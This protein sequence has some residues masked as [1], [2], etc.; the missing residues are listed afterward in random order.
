[1]EECDLAVVGGSFA[2]L[3]CAHAAAGR[4]LRTVVL[5]RKSEPG[6][7][8]HTTGLL[9]K[10]AAEGLGVPARLTQKI[11]GVR[12][13]APSLRSIDLDSP[14][15]YFLATD[16]AG[17]L[18]WLA[19]RA[20]AVGASVRYGC[21]YESAREINE[22]V[23]IN[24]ALAARWIMGADGPRSR[25]ARDFSL[26]VNRRFL[27]GVESEFE[28]VRDV[29]SGRLHCFLDSHLAPGYIAWVIPGVHTTQIGLACSQGH[30]PD[31]EAFVQ[32]ISLLFNFDS[33][34]LVGR[35]GGLI[36]VGGCVTPFSR[37]RATLIGDAAG[38]VS[39]LTAGGIHTALYY[40]ALAGGLAAEHLLHDGPEPSSA[41]AAAYP[42][43][44]WK[45][46][47]RAAFD[48]H[49]PN[50]LIN[51]FF[52]SAILRET[53]RAVFFHHRGLFS[54]RAWCELLRLST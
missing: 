36:P 14:G 24:A 13:Y 11:E 42:R 8:V 43:F 44:F 12:L 28:N 4:G 46:C 49:P 40:G 34:R 32:K 10:E 18:R 1:M 2:G 41:L 16:T 5:D 53:A 52:S 9:V 27:V 38:V 47:M 48:L 30:K 21:E 50:M 22:R 23:E 54:V 39:P 26:G 33:A 7:S 29:D 35:R 19:A 31:L 25:V 20:E 3:S 37:G 6:A 45:R 51:A 17:L 15:Y